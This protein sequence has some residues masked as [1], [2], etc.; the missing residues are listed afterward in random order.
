MKL[1]IKEI[2]KKEWPR[3]DL[4]TYFTKIMPTSY[5]VT[6]DI[7]VSETVQ[8][9]KANNMKFFAV[10]LWLISKAVN[11]ISDFRLAETKDKKLIEYNHIVPIFPVFH[12]DTKIVTNVC[13]DTCQ[14]FEAFLAEYK[15]QVEA[16][17]K[18]NKF[19]TSKYPCT[20]ANIFNFSMEPRIRFNSV[21]ESFPL[22]K[23][24]PVFH[25][26]IIA[27]KYVL[28]DGRYVMPV[29]LQINHAV[30]D[31]YHASVFYELI[32]KYYSDPYSYIK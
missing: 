31:G 8:F 21:S 28:N 16:A 26:I 24:K 6:V 12:E 14:S 7:D 11:E 2:N 32:Q 20:P 10:N 5:S 23:E 3:R 25:P 15:E 4:Y 30:A 9:S 18:T 19:M 29:A 17:R 1:E 13:A 27:G 22:S